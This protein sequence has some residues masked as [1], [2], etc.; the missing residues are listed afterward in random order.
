VARTLLEPVDAWVLT[1]YAVFDFCPEFLPAL[2]GSVDLQRGFEALRAAALL[3]DSSQ[4]ES[5][6]GPAPDGELPAG[7]DAKGQPGPDSA[8][9]NPAPPATAPDQAQAGTTESLA[10][11]R[12]GVP[13]PIE[14]V[15]SVSG[16]G[17][18]GS[19]GAGGR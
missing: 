4:D 8:A 14:P 2:T 17:G 9:T 13:G 12:P 15:S 7:A 5:G 10:R 6:A 11:T 18:S 3:D 16:G 19:A 1:A